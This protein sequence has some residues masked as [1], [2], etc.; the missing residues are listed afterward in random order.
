M[1]YTQETINN[2]DTVYDIETILKQLNRCVKSNDDINKNLSNI[3]YPPTRVKK[4]KLKIIKPKINSINEVF[5]TIDIRQII[6]NHKVSINNAEYD[7]LRLNCI[8]SQKNKIL[9]YSVNLLFRRYDQNAPFNL[10]NRIPM[11]LYIIK[12][13]I[14]F[15]FGL[16]ILF[17]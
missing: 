16:G 8:N 17:Y 13:Y 10:Y 11:I 3:G 1:C 6:F 5:N 14:N 15:R 12:K 2:I 4:Y 9:I 7:R